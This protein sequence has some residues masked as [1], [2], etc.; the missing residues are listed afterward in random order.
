[1]FWFP[2]LIGPDSLKNARLAQAFGG[3]LRHWP[4]LGGDGRTALAALAVGAVLLLGW[5][6]LEVNDDIRALQNPD[7]DLVAQQRKL[8]TLLDTPTP[9]QFY[10]IRAASAEAVL[11]REEALKR[12]LDPLVGQAAISGY[13]AL[14]N[15]VPS[16][17]TQA[18][19]RA[20]AERKL[21]AVDGALPLLAARIDED[22]TWVGAMR[23]RAAPGPSLSLAEFLAAPAGEPWRHLWLGEIEGD[24]ASIV[25]LRGASVAALPALRAAAA[26]L[27]GVQWVDKVAEISSVL[28]RYRE[29]MSWVLLFSY[30]AVFGLLF[31]RYRASAW[32]ALAPTALSSALTVALFGIAGYPLQLFHLLALMLLLGIGVD[33]GIFFRERSQGRSATAWMAVSLSAASTVLAFGLL[34]LSNTPALRAFGL[35]MLLGTALVWLIVP[36]FGRE[37]MHAPPQPVEDTCRV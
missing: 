26:D 4:V 36:C 18:Q 12:K 16:E 7:Q 20:L 27:D 34:G 33:Y 21:L 17:Q 14:S 3:G 32:R 2:A 13:Q 35:T 37:R 8:G 1:V 19:R 10:L 22:A 15:W 9:A 28:G 5:S 25:A 29:Y 30:C 6:H 11:Q 23:E 24:Y 31:V